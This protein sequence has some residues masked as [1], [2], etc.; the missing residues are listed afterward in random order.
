MSSAS[1]T[2]LGS[3]AAPTLFRASRRIHRAQLTIEGLRV[4]GG[5]L[6]ERSHGAERAHR[7]AEEGN[8]REEEEGFLFGWSRH[9]TDGN[10][11]AG[12]QHNQIPACG[13]NPFRF[14]VR[15]SLRPRAA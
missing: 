1:F 5:T 3:A 2:A 6:L 7:G 4:Y 9:A 12:R 10:A 13:S 8:T 14:G 11:I 15:S